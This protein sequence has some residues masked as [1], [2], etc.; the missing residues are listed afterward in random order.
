MRRP[1]VASAFRRKL[2]SHARIPDRAI[3]HRHLRLPARGRGA[4]R[5]RP[6]ARL[7]SDRHRSA[8]HVEF[9]PV[10]PEV[11]MGLGH[12][13]RDAAAGAPHDA[14]V[15]VRMITTRTAI[16]HTD[17]MNQWAARR[18]AELAREEPVFAATCSRRT[19]RAAAWSASRPTATAACPHATAAAS[20]PLRCM[21]RFP[22][23]CRSRKKAGCPI[24]AAR[25]LHRAGLRL[26][27]A[28][29]TLLPAS[30]RLGALVAFHTA[31]KMSLLAHSTTRYNELGR[32]VARGRDLPKRELRARLRAGCS[33]RR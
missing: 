10:C 22:H 23:A 6:Q 31:H 7:V 5:R 11:E 25:K 33:W 15:P 2:E 3:P 21:E 27:A 18:L 29:G 1:M 14:A 26:P 4:L 9:V 19:R 24:P 32:L 17:G 12:A 13:A 16:D 30:G 28:K 8:P 20:S